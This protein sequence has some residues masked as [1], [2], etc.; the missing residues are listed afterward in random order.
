MGRVCA[1]LLNASMAG[2]VFLLPLSWNILFPG[3]VLSQTILTLTKFI[4]KSFNIYPFQEVNYKNIVHN[5]SNDN[6]LISKILLFIH[7]N[8]VKVGLV[9]L[10]TNLGNDIFQDGRSRCHQYSP[11][12]SGS[13]LRPEV[14]GSDRLSYNRLCCC[15]LHSVYTEGKRPKAFRLCAAVPETTS[16]CISSSPLR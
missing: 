14:S 10:R 6:Y 1:F 7:I 13:T 8:L 4:E 3:S 5:R 2:L 15:W 9:W 12:R 16:A 11:S